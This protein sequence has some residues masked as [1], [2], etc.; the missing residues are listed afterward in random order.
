[1]KK[2]RVLVVDDSA[3]VRRMITDTLSL[4]PEIEVVGTAA[5]PY[6]ARDKI[7]ELNPDV[8]TLDIEMPRM[9]GLTFLR[10]LHQHRPIPAV[11]VS[12]VTPSGSRAALQAMELGAVD[13]LAKPTSSWDHSKLREQLAV[14]VKGASK[15]RLASLKRNTVP[16]HG[17]IAA[18]LGTHFLPNQVVVMGAST[19]GTEALKSILTRLPDGLPGIGI[20]QHI[21]PVFSK[22][23]AERL[24][25]CCAFEVR[26][27][28]H[29]DELKPGLALIA[30]GDY[31]MT[32][33]WTGTSHRVS[34]EHGPMLHHSRP[35]VDVLFNS[36]IGAGNHALAVL[37]TGMGYDGAGGMKQ[38]KEA[39][40]TT[41]AQNEETCVVYGMPRAAVQ[42]GVVDYL[43]PLD[44]IPQAILHALQTTAHVMA[45]HP[46]AMVERT[47]PQIH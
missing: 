45:T 20:V 12:A 21:P 35:A 11:V 31:H 6:D 7:L 30:P 15:A 28:A 22:T 37:L 46:A 3:L 16:T 1:M 2:I 38:L 14:R 32:L 5:D 18:L 8:L 39:G 33:T 23:F 34:L 40:A 10:I 41:I 24:N 25:E 27:A 26:E 44:L 43:L 17:K 36:A 19:G 47:E 4:D 9:D 42:L 29:G 13:V